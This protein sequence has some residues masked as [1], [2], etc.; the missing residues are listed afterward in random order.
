VDALATFRTRR[1]ALSVTSP[2]EPFHTTTGGR[3]WLVNWFN[4]Q[5]SGRCLSGVPASTLIATITI[6]EVEAELREQVRGWPAR[7]R[8][9]VAPGWLAYAVL[10]VARAWDTITNGAVHSKVQSAEW[11][12]RQLPERAKLL[13]DA[14]RVR[15]AGGREGGIDAAEAAGFVDEIAHRLASGR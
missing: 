6:D 9:D 14:I 8:T 7:I 3:D 1:S 15:A 2:G 13:E 5:Q 11:A 4:V 12:S 10:T